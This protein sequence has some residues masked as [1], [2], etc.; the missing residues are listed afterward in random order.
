[1]LPL[2]SKI[3]NLTPYFLIRQ[4]LR[5]GNAASMINGMLQ[6][7][8]AKMNMSIVTSWFGGQPSDSGM[9]L[10]QQIISRVLNGDISELKKRLKAIDSSADRPTPEQTEALKAY[11]SMSADQQEKLRSKSSASHTSLPAIILS[12]HDPPLPEPATTAQHSNLLAS[13]SLHLA[14]RDRQ[15]LISTLC[16]TSNR[17]NL[18]PAIRQLVTAY[19]PIIRAVHTAVDLSA[20]TTNLESFLTDLIALVQPILS[21]SG[22]EGERSTP[23]VA[24]LVILLE[25]HAP[26]SHVFIHQALKNSPRDLGAW[27]KDYAG[28]AIQQYRVSPSSSSSSSSSSAHNAPLD[29]G[30]GALSPSLQ[31]L[32]LSV[33]S[34]QKAT[35]LHEL[36]AHASYLSSLASNSHQR[37]LNLSTPS[38]ASPSS[39]PP[40]SMQGQQG[41]GIFLYKWQQLMDETELTPGPIEETARKNANGTG[42]KAPSV[43]NTIELLGP[44]FK[45]LLREK[46]AET[47]RAASALP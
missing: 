45:Q 18:T 46:C 29:G 31:S 28:H 43:H 6:L 36:D 12:S 7:L 40:P 47:Q 20:G 21:R 8:L 32:F 30:A 34:S 3:H 27:Y 19:D 38:F 25:K 14:V 10:L 1:M 9:N 2:L 15:L 41:P 16:P 24:D 11:I 22:S 37:M 17:D 44:G 13:L 42:E 5:I 23:S 26:S 4:T 35:V 39:A 33:A